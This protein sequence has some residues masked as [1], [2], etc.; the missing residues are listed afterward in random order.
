ML[1]FNI[2]PVKDEVAVSISTDISPSNVTYLI[3]FYSPPVNSSLSS[4]SSCNSVGSQ[5]ELSQVPYR[6]PF[7]LPIPGSYSSSSCC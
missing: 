3:P 7:H 4:S 1:P 6:V 2:R 5:N